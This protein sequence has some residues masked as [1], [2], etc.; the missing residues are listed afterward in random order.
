MTGRL[1]YG[2]N[3]T[4]ELIHISEVGAGDPSGYVCP[5]CGMPLAAKKGRTRIHQFVHR[6]KNC[7]FRS[8]YDFLHIEEKL[9]TTLN[10]TQWVK[11]KQE[12]IRQQTQQ[13]QTEYTEYEQD[14]AE[15]ML[16]LTD[17]RTNLVAISSPS[18]SQKQRS[19]QRQANYDVLQQ[20]DAYLTD[21]TAPIPAFERVRDLEPCLYATLR[22][23]A[24][25]Y[26]GGKRW[27]VHETA[28]SN[29]LGR[30]A[31]KRK[32]WLPNWLANGL[33]SLLNEY[34]PLS[35]EVA[36]QKQHWERF[37][38]EK[39]WF[40]SFRFYILR[41]E[42][43]ARE[44]LYQIGITSQPNLGECIR[45]THTDL[46]GFGV[47]IITPLIE[48]AGQGFLDSY[49][50]R[51]YAAWQQG[52]EP[53]APLFAF[54]EAQWHQIQ[55]ELLTL[56]TPHSPQPTGS[57]DRIKA[58]MAQARQ[59]GV[60]VGRPEGR[61]ADERFLAKPK[62][63]QVVA[64]LAANPD[65]SMREIAR[66]SGIAL[67]T[68]CKVGKLVGV[69]SQSSV[70]PVG[71][72]ASPMESNTEEPDP[73]TPATTPALNFM[74]ETQERRLRVLEELQGAEDYMVILVQK[75]NGM[76]I[77]P[78]SMHISKLNVIG[79]ALSTL[80]MQDEAFCEA[81]GDIVEQARGHR[82]DWVR[83]FLAP[84]PPKTK[85]KW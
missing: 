43:A 38:S 65:W 73:I 74:D 7:A 48:L 62:S 68:V 52:L 76:G 51:R 21:S 2:R 36:S 67:N 85:R 54:D 44:P 3:A 34:W 9:D 81:L 55:H 6:G 49:F 32:R 31:N 23:Q 30:K 5:H 1:L 24:P 57:S 45:K 8:V 61:E 78:I 39:D 18:P 20:W 22:H 53:S 35:R 75:P 66:H 82:H 70:D 28:W 46:A 47:V 37:S 17:V 79:P 27:F 40:D 14:M 83:D 72:L 15:L 12:A 77:K 11:E 69:A 33:V 59:E 80:V 50:R 71:E 13:R 4:G 84:I 10:L 19:K 63:Q 25:W 41:V 29:Q 26:G 60:H 64:L 56:V 42:F 58:G 16:D